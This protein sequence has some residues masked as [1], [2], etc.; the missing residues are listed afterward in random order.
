M[1]LLN[2][3]M[4]LFVSS[5]YPISLMRSHGLLKIS[6]LDIYF[7]PM[8]TMVSVWTT[9]FSIKKTLYCAHTEHLCILYD[10]KNKESL[11]P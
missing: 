4:H 5:P 1:I 2:V 10:S 8:K 6:E 9:G 7:T 3:Y 11:S